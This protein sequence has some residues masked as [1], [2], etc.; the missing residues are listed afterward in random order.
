[1]SDDLDDLVLAV[2]LGTGGPKVGLV[3]VRADGKHRRYRVN[4]HPLKVEQ[5]GVLTRR[6]ICTRCRRTLRKGS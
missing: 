6:V 5:G 1:M 3:T 2:D 4:L